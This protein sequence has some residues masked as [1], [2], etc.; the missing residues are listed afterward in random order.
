M[1]VENLKAKLAKY[2]INRAKYP[3]VP[4]SLDGKILLEE[5]REN[6]KLKGVITI[7]AE[8]LADILAMRD[9]ALKRPDETVGSGKYKGRKMRTLTKDEYEYLTGH[10]RYLERWRTEGIKI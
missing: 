6:G 8:T 9:D 4:A 10:K 3:H 2:V 5:H 1:S 7:S